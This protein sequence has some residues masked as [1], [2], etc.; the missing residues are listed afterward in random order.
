MCTHIYIYIY[1]CKHISQFIAVL[2]SFFKCINNVHIKI[3]NKNKG[4]KRK[5]KIV[6]RK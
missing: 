2:A 4:K 1:F 5:K 6:K 3:H